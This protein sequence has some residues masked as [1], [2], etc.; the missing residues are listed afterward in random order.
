[1]KEKIVKERNEKAEKLIPEIIE[2]F[3]NSDKKL[4]TSTIQRYFQLGYSVASY[5][6]TKIISTTINIS[7]P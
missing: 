1:M 6:H 4:M 2:Y 3:K 5:L 7:S